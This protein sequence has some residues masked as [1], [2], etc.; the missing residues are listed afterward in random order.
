VL[1]A[2]SLESEAGTDLT[3]GATSCMTLTPTEGTKSVLPYGTHRAGVG[4]LTPR[5]HGQDV[6]AGVA[7]ADSPSALSSPRVHRT[8][9][10]SCEAVPPSI[11]PAGAQGGTSACST[12]A[13][14]SFVSCIRLFDGLVRSPHH[15]VTVAAGTCRLGPV[16]AARW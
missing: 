8:P 5:P 3:L 14:L 2:A 9:R 11:S 12:G 6:E 7:P 15:V 4:H 16:L 1:P 10:I 13:A